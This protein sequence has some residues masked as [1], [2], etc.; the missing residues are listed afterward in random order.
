[1]SEGFRNLEVWQQAME[2]VEVIYRVT[3]KLPS[4]ERFGLTSQVRRA[5]VAH[6]PPAGA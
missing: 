2:L 6:A 5:A 3:A 1:V 4:E